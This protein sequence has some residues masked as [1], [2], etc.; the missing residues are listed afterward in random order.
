MRKI[1]LVLLII[2]LMGLSGCVTAPVSSMQNQVG[3]EKFYDS[4]GEFRIVA[5][6]NDLYMEKFDGSGN[7]QITN[8][9]NEREDGAFLQGNKIAFSVGH[10]N[11]GSTLNKYYL[12]IIE[13]G[14]A[15]VRVSTV[16]EY[17]SLWGRKN[18]Q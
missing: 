2:G 11:W 10:Y 18:K 5:R 14:E 13:N 7:M 12:A 6:N 9:P 16:D 8:T 17:L 15:T 1:S 4:N 3:Y